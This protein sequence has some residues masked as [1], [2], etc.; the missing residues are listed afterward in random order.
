MMFPRS[1]VKVNKY[2]AKKCEEDGYK[3]DSLRE[4]KRYQEL[5]VLQKV[6]IIKE[7]TVHPVYVLEV[8]GQPICKMLPDFRYIEEGKIVIEDVKSIATITDVYKL[9]KKLLRACFGL[10]VKEILS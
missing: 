2:N 10:E 1:F 6:G 4:R 9:K 5:K 8:N 7:L 3:F